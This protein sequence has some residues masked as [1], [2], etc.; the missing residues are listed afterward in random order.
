MHYVKPN[1]SNGYYLGLKYF[2]RSERACGLNTLSHSSANVI[3]PVSRHKRVQCP[4]INYSLA[5]INILQWLVY[6][7]L[8]I[9][10]RNKRSALAT[11]DIEETH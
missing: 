2:E 5:L 8:D 11:K 1:E 4:P 10:Y 3:E 7:Y 9:L 6:E